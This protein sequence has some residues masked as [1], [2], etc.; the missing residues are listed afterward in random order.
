MKTSNK[1]TMLISVICLA[2]ISCSKKDDPQ[3]PSTS[4][5]VVTPP[6]IDTIAPCFGT[7]KVDSVMAI[8]LFKGVEASR[9]LIATTS[10]NETFTIDSLIRDYYSSTNPHIGSDRI[11]ITFT[12]KGTWSNDYNP[13]ATVNTF[14]VTGTN[15][16]YR[17]DATIMPSYPDS[18]R[19]NINYLHKL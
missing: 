17:D 4:N 16:V 2:L 5:V 7:W 6:P 19:M 18:S 3:P 15:L 8:H 1:I 13:A 10:A 12:N 14:T 9:N 11:A